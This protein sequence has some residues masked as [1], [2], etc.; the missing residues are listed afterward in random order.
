LGAEALKPPV[1]D[2][3]IKA[4]HI[5]INKS[6]PLAFKARIE[7][8]Y[9]SSATT[10]PLEIKMQ[11]VCDYKLLTNIHAKEKAKCLQSMQECILQ[12]SQANMHHLGTQYH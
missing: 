11:L 10:F 6:N 7:A 12:T 3:S 5:E 9:S 8:L 1:A 2:T 4:L